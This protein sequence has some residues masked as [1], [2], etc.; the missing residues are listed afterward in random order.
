MHPAGN[1]EVNGQIPAR[2]RREGGSGVEARDP[3]VAKLAHRS[4]VE[5]AAVWP[6]R[7]AGLLCR[8]R[9]EGA[10]VLAGGPIRGD[11]QAHLAGLSRCGTVTD[12]CVRVAAGGDKWRSVAATVGTRS[13][14][15]KRA[16]AG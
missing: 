7:R 11:L 3:Q 8:G 16:R 15:A 10:D 4:V 6:D 1:S 14:T 2:T 9:G 5:R 13:R 12:P